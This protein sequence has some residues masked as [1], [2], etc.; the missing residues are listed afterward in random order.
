M[1]A[2]HQRELLDRFGDLDRSRRARSPVRMNGGG[3]CALSA[4]TS[5]P[6]DRNT[7]AKLT[8]C[9]SDSKRSER[10]RRQPGEDAELLAEEERLAHAVELKQAALSVALA[11]GRERWVG[12]AAGR[13]AAAAAWTPCER[14]MRRSTRW[15]ARLADLGYLVS[16]LASELNR[17]HS[18][19]EADPARLAEVQERRAAISALQ[20]KYGPELSAVLGWAA[21]ASKRLEVV[22]GTDERLSELESELQQALDELGAPGAVNSSA[23]RAAAAIRLADGVTGELASLAM[24]DATFE[25]QVA[26]REPA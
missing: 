1:S 13:R 3:A 6:R 12:I 20:R 17:Y 4:T 26:G 21:D 22:T 11:V 23:Q 24:P 9:A 16:D 5:S 14:T 15:R 7:A 8:S 2:S 19:V 25:V 10:W 18:S